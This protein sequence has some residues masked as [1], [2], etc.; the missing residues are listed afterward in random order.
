MNFSRINYTLLATFMF[1]TFLTAQNLRIDK[2]EPPNWWV[3]MNLNNVQLMIYGENLNDAIIKFENEN[4]HVV[5]IHKIE[6]PSYT[7][8]DITIP[9][10]IAPGNYK[11]LAEKNG[12]AFKI[13]YPILKR[14]KSAETH[15][16][17][18]KEDVIYLISPDRF[19]NGNI[20]NDT[21]SHSRDEF[22]FFDLNGRHGGDIEG[23]ISKLDYIK[24]LGAT[25]IWITPL[26]E[27]DMYMSYHGY[28]A[29]HLYKVDPRFGSNNLYKK[30]VDEAHNN[31]LKIIYDH[32]ANHIGINHEWVENLPMETWFNGSV[33][34]HLS[35]NHH[36]MVFTDPYRDAS[37]VKQVQEGW[38]TDY[39]PDLNQSNEY[40][41][42]YIIQ[43]TIWWI[44]YAGIDAV[45]EDTYP[46]A[47]QKFMAKWAKALMDEY[48]NF[49][50]L[51]EVWTGET[52]FLAGYVRNS[53]MPKKFNSNLPAITDFAFR[54]VAIRFLKGENSLYHFY[55]LFAKDYLY[56]DPDNLVLFL[57]NHDVDRAMYAANGNIAKYKMALTLL[58]TTRGIPQIYYGTE[59]GMDG[60]GHHGKIRGPFPGGFPTDSL[61]A[62]TVEGRDSTQNSIYSFLN[63]MLSLRGEH[64][65]LSSGKF[66]QFPPED[67]IYNYFKILDDEIIYCALN[68]NDAQ[69][70]INISKYDHLFRNKLHR[71]NILSPGKEI[72][73]NADSILIDPN[74]IAIYKFIE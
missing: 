9:E 32:V 45:R 14:E 60:G 39:M 44:E 58:L 68:E 72:E 62:F 66:V 27:N 6:N 54:D 50:I 19:C 53:F 18:N 49:N 36:K 61:N 35:A 38:F 24:D 71:V 59:I 52:A 46:Y 73:E 28:A 74:N 64:R 65:A 42:H 15:S 34:N 41:S 51:G 26:L 33:K 55:N 31:G 2:I 7:F 4:I 29:T 13:D 25:A 56:P 17:F 8:V 67:G 12:Q 3:G 10:N 37:T 47:D 69:R 1:S 43:N 21:L 63:K 16:G 5:K 11:L 40:M 22:Q 20:E 57:D 70:E 48:P 30:L 23:I